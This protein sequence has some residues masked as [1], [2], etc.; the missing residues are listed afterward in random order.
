MLFQA[1]VAAKPQFYVNRA[2][3]EEFNLLADESGLARDALPRAV[4]SHP[5]VREAAVPEVG[6]SFEDTF[7]SIGARHDGGFT[8]NMCCHF[9]VDDLR[10]MEVNGPDVGQEFALGHYGTIVIDIDK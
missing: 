2:L 3:A 8:V 9:I 7:F 6:F 4:Q 10:G 1:A 5:S